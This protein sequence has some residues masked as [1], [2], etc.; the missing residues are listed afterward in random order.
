VIK[1]SLCIW[2]L[3]YKNMQNYFKQFQPLSR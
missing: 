2:W 3:Q 1:K